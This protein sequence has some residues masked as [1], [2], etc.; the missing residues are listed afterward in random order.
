MKLS[1]K[2]ERKGYDMATKNSSNPDTS[3]WY[4]QST[5]VLDTMNN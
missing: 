4:L 1:G 5:H 2:V 3:Y